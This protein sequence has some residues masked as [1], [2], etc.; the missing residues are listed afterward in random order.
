MGTGKVRSAAGADRGNGLAEGTARNGTLYFSGQ[1]VNKAYLNF[2]T[3]AI[4][5]VPKKIFIE[6]SVGVEGPASPAV[7]YEDG[8]ARY[9]SDIRM[10]GGLMFNDT[11][12]YAVDSSHWLYISY[13][14]IAQANELNARVTDIRIAQCDFSSEAVRFLTCDLQKWG[15]TG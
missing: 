12:M 15:A 7:T 10:I 8:Y 2:R 1:S 13:E 6:F 4:G 14:G 3:E 9:F 5:F 11:L